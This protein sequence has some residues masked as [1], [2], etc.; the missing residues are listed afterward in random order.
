MEE[1]GGGGGGRRA[2]EGPRFARNRTHGG[3]GD[4]EGYPV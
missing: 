1:A 4:M 2:P 3:D